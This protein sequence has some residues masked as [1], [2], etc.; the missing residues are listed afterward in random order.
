MP[1]ARTRARRVACCPGEFALLYCMATVI[2]V[3][4]DCLFVVPSATRRGLRCKL[5]AITLELVQLGM[6]APAAIIDRASCIRVIDVPGV[7]LSSVRNTYVVFGYLVWCFVAALVPLG[8]GGLVVAGLALAAGAAMVVFGSWLSR[9]RPCLRVIPRRWFESESAIM[10]RRC[11]AWTAKLRQ[12]R[13]SAC[14][15]LISFALLPLCAMSIFLAGIVVVGEA[16]KG[17]GRHVYAAIV[18]IADIVFKILATVLSE[19]YDYALHIR[20][21]R[22]VER[23]RAETP[24]RLTA[25]RSASAGEAAAAGATSRDSPVTTSGQTAHFSAGRVPAHARAEAGEAPRV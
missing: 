4:A 5:L 23:L 19:G 10:L 25:P 18:L 1:H 21:R 2:N 16:S 9:T 20:V 12:M 7:P 22:T 8:V 14:M 3:A 13:R 11:D 17:N 6:L 15:V 24:L